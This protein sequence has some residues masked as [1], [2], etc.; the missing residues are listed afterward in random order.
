LPWKGIA[1][2][3]TLL[4]MALNLSCH[5]EQSE[6][7]LGALDFGAIRISSQSMQIKM[8]VLFWKKLQN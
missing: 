4:V 3:L 5:C 1:S 6:A 8:L 7:I 2:S